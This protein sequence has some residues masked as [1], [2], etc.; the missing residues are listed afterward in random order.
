MCFGFLYTG[1][2][3]P[4]L[5]YSLTYKIYVMSNKKQSRKERPNTANPAHPSKLPSPKKGSG[6][7]NER[8][9]LQADQEKQQDQDT[10]NKTDKLVTGQSDNDVNGNKLDKNLRHSP[11]H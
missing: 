8:N 11:A 1:V 5:V 3:T 7:P 6:N 2:K 4:Q 9:N 10:V